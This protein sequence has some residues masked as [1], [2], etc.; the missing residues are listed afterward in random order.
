MF[1][2]VAVYMDQNKAIWSGAKAVVDAVADLN[3]GIAGITGKAARQQT[4]TGGAAEEKA[5]VRDTFEAKIFELGGSAFRPG[6]GK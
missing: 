4:P 3:A 2:T 6:S 5:Q 1:D